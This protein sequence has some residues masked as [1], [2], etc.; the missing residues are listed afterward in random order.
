MFPNCFPIPRTPSFV[1]IVRL[2]FRKTIR[3]HTR[4]HVPYD[5]NSAAR[6]DTNTLVPKKTILVRCVVDVTVFS[7]TKNA[8]MG[9][10][11][12]AIASNAAYS[13]WKRI[14]SKARIPITNAIIRSA[15]TAKRNIIRLIS[16]LF[17]KFSLNIRSAN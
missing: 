11:K 10:N 5:A 3:M 6:M 8:L 1:R 13:V 4:R 15:S 16:V 9:T 14:S 17:N 12:P 7:I 2:H